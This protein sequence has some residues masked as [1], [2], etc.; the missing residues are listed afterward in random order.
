VAHEP[1]T[2]TIPVTVF[3]PIEVRR[4]SRELAALEEHLTQAALRQSG[5]TQAKLPRTSYM[6]EEFAE[7]N[8]LNMLK[9]EDRQALAGFLRELLAHAPMLHM[10]LAS[11]P[12]AAFTA[13]V[14][15]WLRHNI[16]PHTLLRIGLQPTMAAGCAVRTTN[17]WFD[18]SLRHRFAE[19]QQKLLESLEKE[20]PLPKN[21]AAAQGTAAPQ[22][23]ASSPTQG[24]SS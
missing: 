20:A 1:A 14:V 9:K 15:T 4:L 8:H 12:S 22:P 3:G 11:D 19:S 2:F 18:F 17:R 13:K 21:T 24:V 10:S 23:Q 5:E 6:L 7:E 16:H